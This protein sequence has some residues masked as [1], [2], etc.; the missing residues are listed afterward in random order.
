MSIRH[1]PVST[2]ADD[3]AAAL[4][5]DGAA[6]V[7]ALAPA[8]TMDRAAAELQPYVEATRIGRDD[9]AGRST[10]RTGGLIARSQTCRDLVMNPLALA[11]AKKVLSHGAAFQVHLTQV[12]TIGPGAEMQPIHRDQ[13]VFDFFKFPKGFEVQL[14]TIWAMTDFTEQNGATRVIPKSHL[15]DDGLKFEEKDTEPAEMT[16]GSALF[17][18]G[19]I[20]HGGGANRSVSVRCGINLTYSLAWLRQEENQYLSVPLAVAETLP[21]ELLR[22]MGYSYGGYALG[23]V[24]DVRDPIKVV[25]PDL[26]KA[27]TTTL[28][29]AESRFREQAKQ[30]RG[31]DKAP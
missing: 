3:I 2:S 19:S 23:Y 31:E 13:W 26:T 29:D 8:S 18:T 14:N 20:Y 28:A 22:L 11:T 6:I 27:R 12:I 1:L 15:F 17:Y 25:K 21:V 4:A 16:K 24:D 5:E 30:W 10:R 7:D 9:F